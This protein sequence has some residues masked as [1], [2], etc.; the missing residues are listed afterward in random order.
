MT[1]R[2]LQVTAPG[3]ADAPE[4]V[5]AKAAEE[6]PLSKKEKK[7]RAKEAAA[8]GQITGEPGR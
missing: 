7:R 8:S 2:T 3:A 1:W 5:E 4:V 6:K